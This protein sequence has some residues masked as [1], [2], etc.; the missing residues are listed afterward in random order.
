MH[1]HRGTPRE[2]GDGYMKLTIVQVDNC[3]VKDIYCATTFFFT[4]VH[5]QTYCLNNNQEIRTKKEYESNHMLFENL[6]QKII[7]DIN[8]YLAFVDLS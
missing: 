3:E 4:F 7:Y 8:P 5:S 2:R 6:T 1:S